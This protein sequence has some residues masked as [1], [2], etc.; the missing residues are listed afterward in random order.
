MFGMYRNILLLICLGIVSCNA[1]AMNQI[2][3]LVA[4]HMRSAAI[5][6]QQ[7]IIM[8]GSLEDFNQGVCLSNTDYNAR[9]V[10]YKTAAQYLVAV[11]QVESMLA[12]HKDPNVQ[13]RRNDGRWE[14]QEVYYDI[15]NKGDAYIEK[16]VKCLPQKNALSHIAKEKERLSVI[17][18]ALKK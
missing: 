14:R 15:P 6:N 10:L 5:C 4:A 7:E 12:C 9:E 3:S 18:A 1:K 17:V 8:A 2:A 16:V 11:T 13:W